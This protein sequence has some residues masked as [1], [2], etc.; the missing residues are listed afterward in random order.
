MAL[1][2]NLYGA[3]ASASQSISIAYDTKLKITEEFTM[4]D[5]QGHNIDFA[6]PSGDE[7]ELPES[8]E[9][10]YRY[11][12]DYRGSDPMT[13]WKKTQM[14]LS[15]LHIQM[16][17]IGSN[18]KT[19]TEEEQRQI[20]QI[21][22]CEPFLDH[23][24]E[25]Q[26]LLG[27]QNPLPGSERGGNIKFYAGSR[28]GRAILQLSGKKFTFFSTER[29]NMKNN[30][31]LFLDQQDFRASDGTELKFNV[32]NRGPRTWNYSYQERCTTTTR[33]VV[34]PGD[35]DWSDPSLPRIPRT[36]RNDQCEIRYVTRDGMRTVDKIEESW[37][38]DYK[39]S[40]WQDDKSVGH[41]KIQVSDK[42]ITETRGACH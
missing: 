27:D 4:Q 5:D 36:P 7:L 23:L 30:E 42:F 18:S 10:D 19:L 33:E 2:I 24:V 37:I 14:T 15:L 29:L 8:P 25:L 32:V 22:R 39:A 41:F 17:L 1:F 28:G 6:L 12:D 3:N 9:A 16:R 13:D 35:G 38:L 34:C 20:A 21:P 26:N 11:C 40:L 31:P